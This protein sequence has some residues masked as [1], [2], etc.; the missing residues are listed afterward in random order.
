MC[1]E[2]NSDASALCTLI[3]SIDLEKALPKRLECLAD[4]VEVIEE[5]I[6]EVVENG[7]DLVSIR[8]LSSFPPISQRLGSTKFDNYILLL[9]DQTNDANVWQRTLQVLSASGFCCIAPHLTN[10][11]FDEEKIIHF[12]LKLSSRVETREIVIVAS[13]Q[14][15]ATQLRVKALIAIGIS[16]THRL[17]EE[18]LRENPLPCLIVRGT[19]DTSIGLNAANKL[20]HL[21]NSRLVEIPNG[22]HLCHLSHPSQFYKI[23]LNFLLNLSVLPQSMH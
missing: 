23:L 19:F 7:E 11:V 4:E 17:K 1:D 13:L 14:R 15:T 21:R 3:K 8:Y 12:L 9:H 2:T 6:S 5:S 18:E 16:D 20:K 10:F 22:K